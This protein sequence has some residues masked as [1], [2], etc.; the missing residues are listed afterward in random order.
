MV[1]WCDCDFALADW[2]TH[3]RDIGGG[4]DAFGLTRRCAGAR[5]HTSSSGVGYGRKPPVW[6]QPGDDCEIEIEGIG[7]LNNPIVAEAAP[8]ARAA[9]D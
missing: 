4:S 2:T 6:M 8:S 3:G 9:A 5:K 1:G 7:V